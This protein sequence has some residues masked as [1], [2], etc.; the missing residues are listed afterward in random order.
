MQMC[1]SCKN[2]KNIS[3]MTKGFLSSSIKVI[4]EKECSYSFLIYLNESSTLVDL[5]RYV[6][7]FY[8][9]CNENKILYEDKERT[10][11]IYKTEILLKEFIN[12]KGIKPNL[13]N[14]YLF[15]L[16]LLTY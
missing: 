10:V 11:I 2:D 15:Y 4:I 7:Q 16:T 14:S 5:Y 6:E 1:E 9:H 13:N 8:Q 12:I 3:N